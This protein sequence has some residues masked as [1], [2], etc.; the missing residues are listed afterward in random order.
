[1]ENERS[2]ILM[3][4]RVREPRPQMAI[5]LAEM[6][7]FW[8]LVGFVFGEDEV[9]VSRRVCVKEAGTVSP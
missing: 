4:S 6:T 5:H 2:M 8:L 1:M 7:L 3:T 9:A